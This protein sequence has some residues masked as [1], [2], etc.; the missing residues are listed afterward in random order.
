[1]LVKTGGDGQHLIY[2]LGS[3]PII[4]CTPPSLPSS[5]LHLSLPTYF[6]PFVLSVYAF[7][8]NTKTVLH[9]RVNDVDT[10]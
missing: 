9:K 6:P 1:M 10:H 4:P 3:P 2:L 7:T 8:K 5:I